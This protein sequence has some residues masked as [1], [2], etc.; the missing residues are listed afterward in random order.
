MAK[1]LREQ[2][3][4]VHA[5]LDAVDVSKDAAAGGDSHG[6]MDEDT[7]GV[8]GSLGPG[9]HDIMRTLEAAQQLMERLQQ[10]NEATLI[11]TKNTNK[12]Y[13]ADPLHQ[14]E[15]RDRQFVDS[16]TAAVAHME[17]LE[18][19][20]KQF[21]GVN[22]ARAAEYSEKLASLSQQLQQTPDIEAV[23][24]EL[25]SSQAAVLQANQQCQADIDALKQQIQQLEQEDIKHIDAD[26]DKAESDRRKIER[27]LAALKK[28][29]GHVLQQ[30]T[31]INTNTPNMPGLEQRHGQ[32][33]SM[34]A[35]L[36]KLAD[37][38]RREP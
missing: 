10:T 17:Q 11:A 19:S 6:E 30:P 18:A 7:A 38:R 22:A 34:A 37:G 1:T 35:V 9:G 12:N 31:D 2:I 15:Q 27:E 13:V 3:A 32:L 4:A 5:S 16:V 28:H 33:L 29:L 36:N 23:L 14:G 20:N 26:I 25:Q 8:S 21:V 24:S